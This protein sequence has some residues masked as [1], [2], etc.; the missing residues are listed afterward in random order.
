[1]LYQSTHRLTQT[2]RSMRRESQTETE[3]RSRDGD[4]LSAAWKHLQSA[5]PQQVTGAWVYHELNRIAALLVPGFADEICIDFFHPGGATQRVAMFA[6]DEL[7][8]AADQNGSANKDDPARIIKLPLTNGGGFLGSLRATRLPGSEPF[9]DQERANM[10]ALAKRLSAPVAASLAQVRQPGPQ[11]RSVPVAPRSESSDAKLQRLCGVLTHE[12]RNPLSVFR[13]AVDLMESEGEPPG[14][15]HEML[16]LQTER[17]THLVDDLLDMSRLSNGK[18]RLERQPTPLQQIIDAGLG[19]IQATLA[20]KQQQCVTDL[21]PD[22]H[23]PWV[24]ADRF[25]LT[26]ALVNLLSNAAKFSDEGDSIHLRVQTDGDHVEI[27]VSDAGIGIAPDDL[28]TIFD[29]F[30]QCQSRDSLDHSAGGLGIGL[31]LVKGLIEMHDGSVTAHSAGKNNGSTFVVRLPICEPAVISP[32]ARPLPDRLACQR[33]LIVDDRRGNAFLLNALVNK[34]GVA[35]SRC[36]SDGPSALSTLRDY[37][38]DL[39]LLDLGLPGMS[40]LELA[41]EIRKLEHCQDTCLVALTGYDDAETRREAEL[42]G[43]DHYRLKPAS[44]DMLQDVFGQVGHQD[45]QALT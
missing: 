12:L 44:M 34:L 38:P 30:S 32:E 37:H 36:V 40:G 31:G 1:M 43:I 16:K 25:R 18:T 8:F 26:Q 17:M 19:S 14:E 39:V 45:S 41:R 10:N 42:A 5:S 22:E 20:A 7:V 11:S 28:P 6:N 13:T 2:G 33:V 23:A 15:L 9:S 24:N 4:A 29:F 35:E 27:Q 21:A 3:P